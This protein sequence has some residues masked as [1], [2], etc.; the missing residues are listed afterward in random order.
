MPFESGRFS[1]QLGSQVLFLCY[2]SY[3]VSFWG[4]FT[5]QTECITQ[6]NGKTRNR[7]R[8]AGNSAPDLAVRSNKGVFRG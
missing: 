7:A 4:D 3:N 6:K 1:G 5:R 2:H 8:T